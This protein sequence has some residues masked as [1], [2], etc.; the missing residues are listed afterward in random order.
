MPR[1]PTTGQAPARKKPT[2]ISALKLAI[3]VI[4][5]AKPALPIGSAG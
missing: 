1:K 3:M 2:P 4:S 5:R